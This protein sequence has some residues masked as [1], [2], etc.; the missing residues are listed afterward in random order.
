M[1]VVDAPTI[2]EAPARPSPQVNAAAILD[3]R[4]AFV[5]LGLVVLAVLVHVAMHRGGLLV[6]M[7]MATQF[8]PWFAWL[9]DQLASGNVPEWNPT[10]L[11]GMPSA[12]D[13]LSGW[14]YLPVMIPFTLLPLPAAVH[15]YLVVQTA[16]VATGVYVLA[17]LLGLG[18]VAGV[19]AAVV[20]MGNGYVLQRNSCCVA[21]VAVEAWLP[22][23]L[24]GIELAIAARGV[25]RIAA[26]GVAGLAA[27]QLVGGWL[28]QGT[29]YAAVAAAVWLVG[30]TLLA[31]WPWRRRVRALVSNVGGIGVVALG[32]S[33]AALLPRMAI[34][35][36]TNLA[37][38]YEGQSLSNWYAGWW[39][40]DW[41]A[42]VTPGEFFL[43]WVGLA[44]AL[45]GLV[46]GRR[47]RR[48][49][50]AAAVAVTALL[51]AMPTVT[52]VDVPLLAI[53][54]MDRI[55]TH[56]P[57]RALVMFYPV[58]ALLA[59]VGVARLWRLPRRRGLGRVAAVALTTVLIGELIVANVTAIDAGLAADRNPV[60]RRRIDVASFYEPDAAGRFLQQQRDA[61][62][63]GRYAAFAPLRRPDGTLTSA[64]YFFFWQR[65][66]VQRL[67]AHN[68]G[69]LLGLEHTQGYNAVHLARY[70]D[71]ITAANRREQDYHVAN[72]H[73]AAFDRGAFDLLNGRWVVMPA[74]ID[75]TDADLVGDAVASWPQVYA[76][77]RV[78]VL[79]NP[80]ALPRAWLV[81]DA[82]TVA[83][84]AA[85]DLL[86]DGQVDPRTTALLEA[87]LPALDA[88]AA[89]VTRVV[90][91]DSDRLVVD[92][93]SSGDALLLL[94]EIYHPAWTATV[95]GAA[96]PVLVA[97]H[98][99]RAVPV[100]AGRHTVELVMHT[101]GLRLGIAITLGT[102]LGLAVVLLAGRR[103]LLP[104]GRR[105]PS[106]GGP[107][108]SD[109]PDLSSSPDLS[110][111]PESSGD[112]RTVPPTTHR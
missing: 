87:P 19:V 66:A 23:V 75:H 94:S 79:E 38:G 100:P 30:R 110:D 52:P 106:S 33:A 43:G 18:R 107:D 17:R 31:R 58:V 95:D 1:T 55:H 53:P 3:R 83:P 4:D 22:W 28:G 59:G 96:A 76:D 15:T 82:R 74:S 26:W 20:A 61:G 88:A 7:D 103:R 5:G 54:G 40:S 69:M 56:A 34:N 89:G 108:L 13:P 105:A 50:V 72:L 63:I 97:D 27:S 111:A 49:W 60:L 32:L 104:A 35:P 109:S 16:L 84:G 101:P 77:D 85:L 24:V 64:D 62:Q 29:L 47:D 6:G 42:L 2:G 67:E 102:A 99:L 65:R 11:S 46:L 93:D 70:D 12:G 57:Q 8:I 78:T 81:G 71:L 45:V 44:L 48:V 25:R 39:P 91:R 112:P 80:D 21:F 90:A 92:V 37:G 98:V 68:E 9:G 10:V 41:S 86:L 36:S 73:P 14:G 51:L